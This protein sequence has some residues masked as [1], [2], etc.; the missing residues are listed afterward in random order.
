MT[1]F[2]IS[3]FTAPGLESV[4]DAFEANFNETDELG[5]GFAV[6][7]RGELV[8]SLLGGW[9]DRQKTTPWGADTLVPVYSTTKGIAAFVLASLVDTLPDG[10]ETPVATVWPE[11]A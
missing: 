3:G 7:H 1:D 11:F 10:Y 2:P 9:A 8:A 6:Y 4:R 5:A